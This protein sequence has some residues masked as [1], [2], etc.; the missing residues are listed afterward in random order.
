MEFG[1]EIHEY[2]DISDNDEKEAKLVNRR[3]TKDIDDTESSEQLLPDFDNVALFD[4]VDKSDSLDKADN[5]DN[6]TLLTELGLADT[7]VQDD[8]GD[9]QN[10]LLDEFLPKAGGE[11]DDKNDIFD[12]L[13]SDFSL[14]NK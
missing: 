12:K 6:L 4:K 5:M 3:Q 11:D 13:L 10:G 8:F 2:H 14:L 7:N 9:F 1:K